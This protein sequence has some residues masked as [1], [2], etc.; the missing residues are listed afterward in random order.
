MARTAFYKLILVFFMTFLVSPAAAQLE[1]V[2]EEETPKPSYTVENIEVDI[3][4]GNAVQAREEAFEAA[5][6]K[7]YEMLA[8][9]FLSPEELE[10]LETPDINT[11]SLLV[12]DYEVTNEKLSATR[13]KGTYKIRYSP[14]AF[15]KQ[16]ELTNDN[17]MSQ[18][19]GDILV[20]P[21][22]ETNGRS[23]LWQV[24]PFLD[25]WVRARNSNTAGRAIIP[26]GDIDDVTQIR[27]NQGL[28]YDPAALNVM[29]LRYR[30]K[31]VAL[32]T[33]TPQ[34][35][36]DGSTNIVVSLYNVRPY[37]PELVRQ[38]SVRGYPGEIQEQRYNRVVQ[39]VLNALGGGW[40][41]Q[42]PVVNAPNQVDQQPLTGPMANITAQ[43][44]FNSVRQWVDTKRSLER[45]RG[46]K[47]VEVK[48]LSPRSAT[49]G[50]NF[51][52]DIGTLRQSLQKVGIN[53]NDPQTS[54]GQNSGSPIYQLTSGFRPGAY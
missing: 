21:F 33:A 54:Y 1:E 47:S 18:Q 11:V 2:M 8:E 37:G 36:P 17:A 35:R 26:L 39:D 20:L 44:N 34:N 10:S 29:R 40:K 32:M 48:S 46:V 45:A 53:L 38:I 15:A 9:R 31:D 49:V 41:S 52:G 42:T 13:Y 6:I 12:K 5:Q 24:N 3:T 25:A 23:F 50:V 22:F 27:D 30:A 43:L 14:R 51:Q 7:G 19:G 28:N 16:D 4:S